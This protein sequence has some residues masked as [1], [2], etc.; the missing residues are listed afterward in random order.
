[1]APVDVSATGS[2]IFICEMTE[3][4]IQAAVW[5]SINSTPDARVFR[6]HVGRVQDNRGRWHQFGL[7]PGS[8]DLIGWRSVVITQDMVG[9]RVAKFLSLE[10]KAKGGR[11][12]PEQE[13]WLAAVLAAGGEARIVTQTDNDT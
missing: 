10:I 9:Q 3:A 13:R 12:R 4:Q 7:C 1:V 6:N 2:E 5:R 11:V 8:A